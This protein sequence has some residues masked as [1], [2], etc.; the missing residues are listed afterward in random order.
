M[1]NSLWGAILSTIGFI[2][3][4]LFIASMTHAIMARFKNRF[5]WEEK[6]DYKGFS[7]FVSFTWPIMVP[8]S[9]ILLFWEF[10]YNKV[11]GK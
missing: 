2:L 11:A 3:L 8:V 9:L 5:D 10:V 4:Y 1:F 6:D 7:I